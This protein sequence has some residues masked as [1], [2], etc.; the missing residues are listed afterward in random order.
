MVLLTHVPNM[1]FAVPDDL[2]REMRAHN[3]IKW[4]E[5]CRRAIQQEISRLHAYDRILQNSKL[6]EEDAIELGREIN[7]IVSRKVR[8]DLDRDS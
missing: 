5:I 7:R 3:E 4:P 8:E 1:T 2:H 6:T